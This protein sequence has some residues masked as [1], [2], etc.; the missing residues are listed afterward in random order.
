MRS[1]NS[2]ANFGPTGTETSSKNDENSAYIY[3]PE[4]GGKLYSILNLK[5]VKKCFFHD[6]D[7]LKHLENLTILAAAQR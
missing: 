6:L 7:L 5:S 1:W 3:L 4:N 2:F